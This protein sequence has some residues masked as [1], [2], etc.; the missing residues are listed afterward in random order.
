MLVYVCAAPRRL[1]FRRWTTS[2]AS[3]RIVRW[4]D[5]ACG[6]E[7]LRRWAKQWSAT[8]TRVWKVPLSD[9]ARWMQVLALR[10]FSFRK[11]WTC[12]H[13]WNAGNP[14]AGVLSTCL[15]ITK[16]WAKQSRRRKRRKE[17]K[18]SSLLMFC[19]RIS[20]ESKR[21]WSRYEVPR[22]KPN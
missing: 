22:L 9:D 7:K 13:G 12:I 6:P 18:V 1:F 11:T 5:F 16:S 20:E 8:Q 15:R 14:C 17:L 19:L 10:L 3:G 4:S 21:S 2:A